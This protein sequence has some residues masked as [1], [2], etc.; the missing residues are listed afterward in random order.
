MRNNF[1]FFLIFTFCF[2]ISIVAAANFT[3]I[4]CR[5]TNKGEESCPDA[6]QNMNGTQCRT[7]VTLD[8]DKK[9]FTDRFSKKNLHKLEYDFT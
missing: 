9:C 2:V 5:S 8:K 1:C 3:C 4:R 7:P 6:V